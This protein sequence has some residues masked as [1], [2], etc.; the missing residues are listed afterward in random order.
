MVHVAPLIAP[1]PPVK[2]PASTAVV[3]ATSR[4]AHYLPSFWR[5]RSLS[6]DP[7]YIEYEPDFKPVFV[8]GS[9]LTPSAVRRAA[10]ARALHLPV[11]PTRRAARRGVAARRATRG[12]SLPPSG[13]RYVRTI[14]TISAYPE[15]EYE[16]VP[17]PKTAS[18]VYPPPTCP[19]SCPPFCAVFCLLLLGM[20]YMKLESQIQNTLYLFRNLEPVTL[21]YKHFLLGM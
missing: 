14:P 18:Q 4:P 15:Y 21:V 9:T 2:R 12:G 7:Y 5:S 13:R 10:A 17:A 3:V 6:P 8:S 19:P 16:Y 20:I 11:V 1:L